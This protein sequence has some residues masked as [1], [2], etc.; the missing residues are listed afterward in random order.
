M[1]SIRIVLLALL[2]I[3]FS[4]ADAATH[5]LN[6]SIVQRINE[7]HPTQSYK[8]FAGSQNAFYVSAIGGGRACDGCQ[9]PSPFLYMTVLP[10][11]TRLT[12]RL[13]TDCTL[14]TARVHTILA[15]EGIPP[16]A[17]NCQLR[18]S[19]PPE[20]LLWQAAA[21]QG[22]GAIEGG[23]MPQMYMYPLGL[24]ISQSANWNWNLLRQLQPAVANND[25][26]LT[27]VFMQAGTQ[28]VLHYFPCP[29]PTGPSGANVGFIFG[30]ADDIPFSLAS[31][32]LQQDYSV[33]G[34]VQGLYLMYDF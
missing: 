24:P 25:G 19:L 29:G 26:V 22:T 3:L 5:L 33:A 16:G 14:L 15:F 8:N 20:T 23:Y 12:N 27:G 9:S 17:T 30:M 21:A 18:L 11:Q 4:T 10:D 2:A 34:D 13:P 28:S 6:P 31:V 7:V 1:E 32:F